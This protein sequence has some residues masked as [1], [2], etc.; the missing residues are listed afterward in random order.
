MDELHA[1]ARTV[2]FYRIGIFNS[3]VNPVLYSIWFRQF[4]LKKI[5][6]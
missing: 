6:K 1:L 5:K 3:A 2:I 4:R